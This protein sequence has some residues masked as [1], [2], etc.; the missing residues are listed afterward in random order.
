[1]H[2]QSSG[3]GLL[4]QAAISEARHHWRL[5]PATRAGVPFESW[6]TLRVVFRIEGHR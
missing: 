1:M 4:D 3:S 2:R 6:Y 5:R